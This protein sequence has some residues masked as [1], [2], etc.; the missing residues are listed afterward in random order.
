MGQRGNISE[1]EHGKMRIM[2]EAREALRRIG[3]EYHCLMFDVHASQPLPAG[4]TLTV[5]ADGNCVSRWFSADE[6]EASQDRGA[7]PDVIQ[8]IAKLVARVKD[9]VT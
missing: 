4:A 2:A 5:T 3:I 8:Q 6:I 7:R 9:T 1:F